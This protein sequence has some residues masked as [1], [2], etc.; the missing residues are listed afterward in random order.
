MPKETFDRLALFLIFVAMVRIGATWSVLS[1]TTDEPV[2]VTAGV[3][4]LLQ[5]RNTVLPENPPLARILFAAPLV[6]AGVDF[7]PRFEAK[8]FIGASLYSRGHYRTN[9]VLARAGN[10]VFFVLASLATWRL[11]RRELG[12]ETGLASLFLFT[13]QPLILGFAG[14]ANH[15]MAAI[16]GVALAL[17][18]FSRWLE[19]RTVSRALFFGLSFGLAVA[20]KFSCLGFV[21]AAC[22]AYFVVRSLADRALLRDW[23]AILTA[24]PI[25]LAA[26]VIVLWSSY[27]L[28]VGPQ[29]F[30]TGF[31]SMMRIA[32]GGWNGYALGRWNPQGWWW[33][34]PLALG[35]KTTLASLAF[36]LA[37]PVVLRSDRRLRA[38]FVLFAVISAAIL[39]VVLP[40][41]L[42]IG[43]RYV[44]AIFVPLSIAMGVAAVAMWQSVRRGSRVAAVALLVLHSGASLLAPP[45]YIAY[46]NVLAGRDPSRVLIDSNLDWGQDALLLKRALRKNRVESVGLAIVGM[47][48]YRA[49]GFPAHYPIDPYV[50]ATGWV[51]VSDHVYRMHSGKGGWKWLRGR[52]YQRVGASIRLYA[53]PHS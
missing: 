5:R 37:A 51:A 34:F 17:L 33:Y 19:R 11:A 14:I 7:D 53:I 6:M 21:P 2:H 44:L 50:P 22:A 43:V 47:H 18:A 13:T 24:I 26:G 25:A 29:S 35:V 31:T 45:E 9:L 3:E 46:F 41:K 42:D 20:L 27:A 40:V 8:H 12:P 23:R 52:D 1:A 49:L 4:S 48:D 32:R 16:A 30:F 28:T 15:D 36:L 39:V 10:L 38:G